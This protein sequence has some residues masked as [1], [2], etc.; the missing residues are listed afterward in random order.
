MEDKRLIGVRARIKPKPHQE[1]KPGKKVKKK[2]RALADPA[3]GT[4]KRTRTQTTPACYNVKL[5]RS[6]LS[7]RAFHGQQLLGGRASAHATE[8][9][10]HE[11]K[12]HGGKEAQSKLEVIF[13]L[14]EL[15]EVKIRLPNGADLRNI[16]SFIQQLDPSDPSQLNFSMHDRWVFVHPAVLAL[17]ACAAEVVHQAGG[18]FVG[19]VPYIRSLTYLVRMKLFDFVRMPPPIVIQEHEEA[20]RFIP[21]TQIRTAEDL[22]NAITKLVPLLHVEPEVADPIKYV[23][24]EM[25]RNALEHSSS[26][27]GAFVAAQYYPKT[28]RSRLELLMPG[29]AFLSI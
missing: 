9:S 28:K 14:F 23:F 25:V 17:T 16:T 3:K 27:V 21:L 8:A 7:V 12:S 13:Y 19:E 1:M 11:Q 2:Q 26:S 15:R 6:P 20:G 29:S 18:K 22:R 24:S 10:L 4:K 5:I